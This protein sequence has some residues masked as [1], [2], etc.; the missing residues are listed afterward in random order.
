M[1]PDTKFVPLICL[2]PGTEVMCFDILLLGT[3][4][5]CFNI[6]GIRIYLVPGT[7]F[8]RNV[9]GFIFGTWHGYLTHLDVFWYQ[10]RN[11]YEIYLDIFAPGTV[12]LRKYIWCQARLFDVSYAEY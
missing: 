11:L 12:I 7:K 8:I 4:V 9:W 2:E 3:K 1:V 6:F 10:V 5:M